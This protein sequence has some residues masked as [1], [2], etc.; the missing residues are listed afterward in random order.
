MLRTLRTELSEDNNL[1]FLYYVDR[2][3]KE[4]ATVVTSLEGCSFP[5]YFVCGAKPKSYHSNVEYPKWYNKYNYTV[6]VFQC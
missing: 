4:S 6:A 5:Q 2:L 1:I 3:S